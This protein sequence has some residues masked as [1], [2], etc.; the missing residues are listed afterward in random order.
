MRI[1]ILEHSI[2]NEKGWEYT[3]DNSEKEF[4]LIEREERKMEFT[5]SD[6]KDGDVVTLRNGDRLIHNNGNFTD[7]NEEHDNY[8]AYIDDLNDDL[9]CE[10]S[11]EKDSDIVKVERVKEYTTVYERNEE[12]KEMTVEEV[13]K[14]LGYEVKIV[15]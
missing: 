10:D 11:D 5:K 9:T 7:L 14:A 8:L 2:K 3:V 15:K 4:E 12:V 13:S 1:K 6:L